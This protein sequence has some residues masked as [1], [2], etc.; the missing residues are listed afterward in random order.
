MINKLF[1]DVGVGS[2]NSEAWGKEKDFTII[3]LEPSINRYNDC[4]NTY[5]GKLLNMVAADRN[6]EINCWEDPE[7]GVELFMNEDDMKKNFKRFK[8]EAIKL[9]S[10]EWR[11]F[12][13]IHIW[14]DIEGSELLMLKGA[15]KML[16]SGKVKWI[17]LELREKV[18]AKGW[19]IASQ[20][21]EFLDKYGFKPTNLPV[22]KRYRDVIFV[23]KNEKKGKL[24]IR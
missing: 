11:D 12:D 5:P 20:V 22:G 1:I 14:A 10:L 23:P 3:G 9:D 7:H 16:S 17:N 8:K 18:P 15:T 24:E 2:V 19:V 13:E 4:K 6:G 21:Y